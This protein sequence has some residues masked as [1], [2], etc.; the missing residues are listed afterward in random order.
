MA[1]KLLKTFLEKNFIRQKTSSLL[2]KFKDLEYNPKNFFIIHFLGIAL[3][4]LIIF[5]PA[6]FHLPRSDQLC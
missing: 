1:A 2:A 4:N 3:F 5:Y 6:F